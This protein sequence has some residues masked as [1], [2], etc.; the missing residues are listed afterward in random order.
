MKNYEVIVKKRANNTYRI[1]VGTVIW[2]DCLE[3]EQVFNAMEKTSME[4]KAD[5]IEHRFVFK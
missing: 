3:K 5:G 4:L 2:Y 1:C